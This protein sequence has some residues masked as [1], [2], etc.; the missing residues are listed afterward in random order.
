M[1]KVVKSLINK[2]K[3]GYNIKLHL[4]NGDVLNFEDVDCDKASVMRL[5]SRLQGAEVDEEQVW[6]LIQDHL[7]REYTVP[8]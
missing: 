8:R 6:Y 1:R 4:S 2:G 7:V 5:L 3:S